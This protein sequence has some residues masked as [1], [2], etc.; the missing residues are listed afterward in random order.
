MK[1]AESRFQ[2]FRP[3][4]SPWNAGARNV[5]N[6]L[7]A[8]VQP[9]EV[10]VNQAYERGDVEYLLALCTRMG[11]GTLAAMGNNAAP[12]RRRGASGSIIVKSDHGSWLGTEHGQAIQA[13]HWRRWRILLLAD[14]EHLR[15][16]RGHYSGTED[17]NI[18]EQL[19][20][21][22]DTEIATNALRPPDDI[23]AM[24]SARPTNTPRPRP[25]DN[26]PDHSVRQSIAIAPAARNRWPPRLLGPQMLHLLHL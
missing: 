11:L 25:A 4:N 14:E 10:P 24:A 17:C 7:M 12:W 1:T 8:D 19:G 3:W 15:T 2:F 9:Q 13:K 20:L 6:I 21:T 18:V 5:R 23:A 16:C 22:E 26:D